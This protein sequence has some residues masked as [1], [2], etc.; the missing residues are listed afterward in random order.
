MDISRIEFMATR[1]RGY[2]PDFQRS[3]GSMFVISGRVPYCSFGVF[4]QQSHGKD[5]SD[6]NAGLLVDKQ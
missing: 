3:L 2:S 4:S 1:D 5:D 6:A